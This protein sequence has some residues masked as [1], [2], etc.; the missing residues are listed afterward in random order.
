[1]SKIDSK[2]KPMEQ[3]RDVND[4]DSYEDDS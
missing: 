4:S 3:T 1:M 2:I